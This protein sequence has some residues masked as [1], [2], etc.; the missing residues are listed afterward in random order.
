MPAKTNAFLMYKSSSVNPRKCWSLVSEENFKCCES[1]LSLF[2]KGLFPRFACLFLYARLLPSEQRW[3][4]GRHFP[5]L[6]TVGLK[7]FLEEASLINNSKQSNRPPPWLPINKEQKEVDW[8]TPPHHPHQKNTG[9]KV[10]KKT[11]YR[12][13]SVTATH[14]PLRMH[15]WSWGTGTPQSTQGW[16]MHFIT[17]C[18]NLSLVP[19]TF[20]DPL[21]YLNIIP[22]S[23]NCL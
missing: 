6:A 16:P 13:V 15:G 10:L 12:Q 2:K 20:G 1:G 19:A 3:S 5:A 8:K 18:T 11:N 21:L 17:L 9:G 7:I 22:V 4:I 23:I 14:S